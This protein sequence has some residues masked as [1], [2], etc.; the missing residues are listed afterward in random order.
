MPRNSENGTR[1]GILVFHD[2]E[3]ALEK[4]TLEETGLLFIAILKYSNHCIEPDFSGPLGMAWIFIKPQL[5]RSID[6]YN[7]SVTQRRYA[8]L[9]REHKRNGDLPPSYEE[10]LS[11][12]NCD[13]IG[14]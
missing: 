5:N 12:L 13:E 11:S 6:S 7:S 10:F 9:C 14:R 2:I 8:A 4:L 1:P 3:P